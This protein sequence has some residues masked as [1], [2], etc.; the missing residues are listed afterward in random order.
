[1]NTFH[2]IKTQSRAVRRLPS[3]PK[4]QKQFHA[5]SL[6]CDPKAHL[7]ALQPVESEALA[8]VQTLREQKKSS[9]QKPTQKESV[10]KNR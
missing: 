8:T 6:A 4:R 7:Q 10:I 5:T 9:E 3:L 2:P 1:V